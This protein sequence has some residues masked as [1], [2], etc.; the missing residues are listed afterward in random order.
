MH[1]AKCSLNSW[2]DETSTLQKRVLA[3][4]TDCQSLSIIMSRALSLLPDFSHH[5]ND[6]KLNHDVSDLEY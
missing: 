2:I 5:D 4:S 6:M 3:G 1:G